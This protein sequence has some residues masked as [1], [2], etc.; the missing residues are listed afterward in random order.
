VEGRAKGIDTGI[1]PIL[2]EVELLCFNS[3]KCMLIVSIFGTEKSLPS[4]HDRT[5]PSMLLANPW[6]PILKD[7]SIKH[8]H[9]SK[10]EVRGGNRGRKRWEEGEREGT[11]KRIKKLGTNECILLHKHW[12]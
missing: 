5:N 6:S 9:T 4:L 3:V 8:V 10:Y 11:I 2:V 7:Y 1:L 12:R